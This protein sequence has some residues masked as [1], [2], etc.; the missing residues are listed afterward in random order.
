MDSYGIHQA[1]LQGNSMA[2]YV[3][4]YNDKIRAIKQSAYNNYQE[5]K[6]S[7]KTADEILNAHMG[8]MTG[9]DSLS[10]IH[11]TYQTYKATQKYGGL[12]NALVRG[13]Q[14]NLFH[15]SGGRVGVP[16]MGPAEAEARGLEQVDYDLGAMA[17]KGAGSLKTAVSTA[18]TKAYSMAQGVSNPFSSGPRV[19]ANTPAPRIRLPAEVQSGELSA[20]EYIRQNPPRLAQGSELERQAIIRG[21]I[22]RGERGPLSPAEESDFEQGMIQAKQ[23]DVASGEQ[24]V[25]DMEFEQSQRALG[26]E[27]PTSFDDTTQG[28]PRLATGGA[29]QGARGTPSRPAIAGSDTMSEPQNPSPAEVQQ[30]AGQQGGN[31]LSIAEA[32]EKDRA[33][34][35]SGPQTDPEK[36]MSEIRAT[37]QAG[38]SD[39]ALG[40]EGKTIKTGLTTIGVDSGTAHIVGATAGVVTG[41]AEGIE[42]G[43][44]QW[45]DGAKKWKAENTAEKTGAVLSEAGDVAGVISAVAPELAPIGAILGVA[46]TIADWVGGKKD[47]KATAEEQQQ[48]YSDAQQKQYMS[49]PSVKQSVATITAPSSLQRVG[50]QAP[51]SSY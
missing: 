24:Q 27:M 21:Q 8:A 18:S 35:F 23:R 26:N 7:D 11:G 1:Q 22:N 45:G 37:A 10:A 17:R 43:V 32:Q 19:S 49:A 6:K 42:E 40:L 33:M 44:S 15:M 50:G 14:D 20:S 9:F 4:S 29:E 5:A 30:R 25:S 48:T 41:L 13:T 3:N 31:T 36:S 46:G 2:S 47:E 38:E 28:G 39:E 34:G 51:T 12:G 16:A